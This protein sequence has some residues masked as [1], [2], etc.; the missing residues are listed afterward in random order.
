MGKLQHPRDTKLVTVLCD[1]YA[2]YQQEA[3]K[4]STRTEG[5]AAKAAVSQVMLRLGL[6]EACR[7]HMGRAR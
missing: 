6:V 1:L 5:M 7:E 3:Q 4:P 2:G